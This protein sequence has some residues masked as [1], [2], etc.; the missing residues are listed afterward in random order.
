MS[1]AQNRF[2]YA[3]Q[4]AAGTALGFCRGIFIPQHRLGKLQV[5]VAVFVP[6]ELIQC[7]GG[8]VKAVL[9]HRLGDLGFGFLQLRDNPTVGQGKLNLFTTSA[10]IFAFGVHQHVARGVPQLVAEVA[11]AIQAAHIKLDITPG[12]GLGEEGKAQR[13][14]AVGFNTVF[15]LVL[16]R[17]GNRLGL[18]RLHH[19]AGALFEQLIQ[20]DAVDQVDGVEYVALGFG[21]LL[22]LAVAHQTV[23]VNRLERYLLGELQGHHD[24]PGNPEEDDVKA[25]DQHAAGV[26]GLQLWR[27]FRPAEGAE[28]PQAR[29]EPGI[30]YV[31]ILRQGD[32]GAELMLLASLGFAASNVDIAFLVVPG[33]DAVAPP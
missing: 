19:I 5:P 29:A 22:P 3:Y 16:G 7:L 12:G 13:I 15:E 10:A 2:E 11:V 23:Y 32:I 30:E 4:R 18:F 31:F 26:E 8:V 21:H 25:G 9:V 24:H 33:R 1:K 14:G 27:L 20:R 17:F 6:D 28:R